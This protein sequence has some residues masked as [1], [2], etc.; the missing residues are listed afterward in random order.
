M[1]VVRSAVRALAGDLS[2]VTTGGRGTRFIIDLPLTLMIVDALLVH[3]SGQQMA[4]PQPVLREILQVDAATIVPFENNDVVPYRGTVLPVIRLA[5]LFGL[6]EVAR[7]SVYLLVVGTESAPMALM[8]DRLVA[9]R[10]IVVH[11]VTDPLVTVPGVSGA[12]ELGDGRVSLILDAAAILRLA[13]EQQDHRARSRHAPHG[14]S[15]TLR[16]RRPSQRSS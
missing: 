2:V 13:Q 3:V 8:V 16:T 6:A 11:P 5:R 12:T 10:E 14:M 9:L 7:P 15:S 1:D 4:V